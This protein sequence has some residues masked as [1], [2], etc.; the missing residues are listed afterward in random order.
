MTGTP[1]EQYAHYLDFLHAQ[2]AQ[3]NCCTY[4]NIQQKNQD[5][6]ITD[7]GTD[8]FAHNNRMSL[9]NAGVEHP[10]FSLSYK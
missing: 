10:P 2:K 7:T 6:D 9:N 3:M 5:T 1:K 8:I 4:R